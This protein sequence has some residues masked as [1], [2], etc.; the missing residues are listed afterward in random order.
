MDG[1]VD[2][3]VDVSVDELDGPAAAEERGAATAAAES[4]E[5]IEADSADAEEVVVVVCVAANDTEETLGLLALLCEAAD[6]NKVLDGAGCVM[7]EVEIEGDAEEETS[8]AQFAVSCS[9][10]N[11]TV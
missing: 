8:G 1:N 10:R 9:M 7:T 6:A 4:A 3:L 11:L 2:A 5:R